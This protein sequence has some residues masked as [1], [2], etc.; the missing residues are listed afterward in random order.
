MAGLSLNR[1][2]AAGGPPDSSGSDAL[3]RRQQVEAARR[4][5]V[6]AARRAASAAFASAASGADRYVV[7][8][9]GT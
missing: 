2:A 9:V 3:A 5:A 8:E 6:D 4:A 7:A 1:P